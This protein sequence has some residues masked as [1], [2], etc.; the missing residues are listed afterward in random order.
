MRFSGPVDNF[1][2]CGRSFGGRRYR[3]LL[4]AGADN[5]RLPCPTVRLDVP[6]KVITSD[7]ARDGTFVPS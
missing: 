5:E 2:L 1:V 7:T 4:E 3:N 6:R